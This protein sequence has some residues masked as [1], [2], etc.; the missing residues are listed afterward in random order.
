MLIV[1]EGWRSGGISAE[2]SARIHEQ[3]FYELD[4]PVARLC[5][6]EVPIPYAHH[7][8]E[9][10]L[11][12]VDSIIA[13]VQALVKPWLTFLMPSLGADMEAGTLVKWRRGPGDTVKRGDIIAEVD[14]D[15]GVIDIECFESG[16]VERL[17]VE[18]GAKVPVGTVLAEI[19]PKDSAAVSAACSCQFRRRSRAAPAGTMATGAGAA[20]ARLAAGP[21]TRAASW[22]SICL[23]FAAPDP[24]ARSRSRTWK[25]SRSA[26]PLRDISVHAGAGSRHAPRHRRRHGQVEARDSRTTTCRPAST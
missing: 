9:A 12:Q 23:P 19:R 13:A 3:A 20:R 18:A 17:V 21:E 7:L 4:R 10:A 15:K 8:E 11:P 24:A 5:T 1:D 26:V 16:V 22:A 6:A 14:T 2:I 25:A